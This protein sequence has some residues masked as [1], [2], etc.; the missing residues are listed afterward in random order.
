M[1]G[2]ITVRSLSHS[3]EDPEKVTEAIFNVIGE[4]ELERKTVRGHF[5]NPVVVITGEIVR[6][7]EAEKTFIKILKSLEKD[8]KEKLKKDLQNRVD[9]ENNLH[10]RFDKQMAFSEGV[11]HLISHGDAIHIRVK[12]IIY[13]GDREELI[14]KLEEMIDAC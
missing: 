5:G 9:E 2:R 3:T 1:I 12:M 4:L 14:S 13:S 10:L 11:P 6:R 8:D 7:K